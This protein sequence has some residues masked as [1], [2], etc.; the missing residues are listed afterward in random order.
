[1]ISGCHSS[2]LAFSVLQDL[3]DLEAFDTKSRLPG[4]LGVSWANLLE[5]DWFFEMALAGLR[6]CAGQDF[7]CV[8]ILK[9]HGHSEGGRWH[10][11]PIV[12]VLPP[13]PDRAVESLPSQPIAGYV[14][15]GTSVQLGYQKHCHGFESGSDYV[16]T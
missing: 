12:D 1:M 13:F 11:L 14:L 6:N 7:W 10:E 3:E 5:L 9:D 8:I 4:V 2:I 15:G 16:K